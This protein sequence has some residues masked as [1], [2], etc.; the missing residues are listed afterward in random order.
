MDQ[1]LR[2]IEDPNKHVSPEDF[3]SEIIK[4]FNE[5]NKQRIIDI[6]DSW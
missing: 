4:A 6:K 1:F 3:R 2:N 5:K